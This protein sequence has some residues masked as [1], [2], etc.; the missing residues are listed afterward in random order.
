MKFL[1]RSAILVAASA[2][3]LSAESLNVLLSRMDQAAKGTQSVSADL[4]RTEYTAV[5]GETAVSSGSI[6]LKRSRAGTIGVVE[7]TE[8]DPSVVHFTGKAAEKYMPKAKLLEVYEFGKQF[9]FLDQYLLLGFGTPGS[10][11]KKDYQVKVIGEEPVAGRNTTRLEL[12]PKDKDILD[13]IS[14][15]ELWIPAGESNTVQTKV[16]QSSRNYFLFE[17]SGVEINPRLPDAA[18]EFEPPAGVQRRVLK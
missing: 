3:L 15:I 7:F 1:I 5:L 6:R 11:L 9:K 14:K 18:F 2:T 17:Y 10:E 12:V 16:T 13:M 4:K 8:P